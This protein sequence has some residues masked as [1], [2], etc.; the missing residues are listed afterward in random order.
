[1]LDPVRTLD[2]QAELTCHGAAQHG[3]PDYTQLAQILVVEKLLPS[4]HMEQAGE[5]M[6]GRYVAPVSQEDPDDEYGLVGGGRGMQHSEEGNSDAN[7]E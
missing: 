1:L 3:W 7:E 6:K 2:V 4:G 5:A